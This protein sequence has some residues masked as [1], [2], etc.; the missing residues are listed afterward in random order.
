LK[1]RQD[2]SKWQRIHNKSYCNDSD[3]GKR[4][5]CLYRKRK[6]KL[7]TAIKQKEFQ[8]KI[9]LLG[10]SVVKIEIKVRLSGIF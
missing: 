1:A 5:S 8:N 10:N 3:L 2:V 4:I 7:Q 6:E 9:K